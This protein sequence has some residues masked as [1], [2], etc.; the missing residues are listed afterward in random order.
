M[1][2]LSRQLALEYAT[3]QD[4]DSWKSNNRKSFI[5]TV[6]RRWYKN[7]VMLSTKTVLI[8]HQLLKVIGACLGVMVL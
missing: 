4:E 1:Y 7:S 3:I 2:S 5:V 6:F 8:A